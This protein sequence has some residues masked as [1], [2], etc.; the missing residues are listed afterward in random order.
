MFPNCAQELVSRCVG[1]GSI[2]R[3]SRSFSFKV[4]AAAAAVSS[5]PV[6]VPSKP[7]EDAQNGFDAP[8]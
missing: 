2:V 1:F 5:A 3:A 8:L 7:P 6:P 4:C